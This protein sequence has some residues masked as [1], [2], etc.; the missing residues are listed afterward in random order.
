MGDIYISQKKYDEAISVLTTAT[1]VDPTY[2]N[3][4][5]KLGI[6]YLEISEFA[7][8][9]T[10]LEMATS[11]DE[12]DDQAWF[13]LAQASNELNDCTRGKE[14][15]ISATDLKPRFG[16][17]WYEMARAEWCDGQGNKTAALNHLEK[18][19]T[20]RAWRKS[21]E[22]LMDKIKNPHKYEDN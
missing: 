15:A 21:A 14:A 7:S 13:L 17:G 11:L 2:S 18:A 8:A 10:S 5:L 12:K 6:S 3:G 19:R 4:Y 20:D 1:Q 9:Q 22:Y 16:G